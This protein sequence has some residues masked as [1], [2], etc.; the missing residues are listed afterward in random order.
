MGEGEL[1]PPLRGRD[2]PFPKGKERQQQ[3]LVALLRRRLQ[4]PEA[5]SEACPALLQATARRCRSARVT[6]GRGE[7]LCCLPFLSLGKGLATFAPERR[8]LGVA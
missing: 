1:A 5:G 2:F 3:G 8:W 4:L 6:K 7:Q